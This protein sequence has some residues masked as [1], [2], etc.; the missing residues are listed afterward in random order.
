MDIKY[1]DII[2]KLKHEGIDNSDEFAQFYLD[3]YYYYTKYKHKE[4]LSS[5][6]PLSDIIVGDWKMKLR[7]EKINDIL[8]ITE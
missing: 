7:Q 2:T 6:V 3:R 8:N 5:N 4:Y 1:Q